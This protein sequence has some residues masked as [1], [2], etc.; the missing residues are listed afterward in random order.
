MLKYLFLCAYGIDRSPTAVDVA[1]QIAL[2]RGLELE[3]SSRG[4]KK[5]WDFPDSYLK[6]YFDLFDEVFVMDSE[7]QE[8]V[9][10]T[11]YSAERVHCLD[12]T[13]DYVRGDVHLVR[14]L[15]FKLRDWI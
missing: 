6:S 12:I 2:E 9:L 1:R 14:E 3:A 11:G 10:R 8:R 13:D 15:E 4:F 5:F 7:M